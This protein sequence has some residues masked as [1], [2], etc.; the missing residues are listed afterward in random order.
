MGFFRCTFLYISLISACY[1]STKSGKSI[2]K[3]AL[4]CYNLNGFLY[5]HDFEGNI[6]L[7]MFS[8]EVHYGG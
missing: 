7:I 1:I 6:I 5:F 4:L 2:D 8:N 3:W